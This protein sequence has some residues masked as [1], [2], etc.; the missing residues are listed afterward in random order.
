MWFLTL[1]RSVETPRRVL[2]LGWFLIWARFVKLGRGLMT[3]CVTE[4]YHMP[5]RDFLQILRWLHWGH[6]SSYQGK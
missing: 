5:Q 2:K 4:K 1:A 6:A 3:M